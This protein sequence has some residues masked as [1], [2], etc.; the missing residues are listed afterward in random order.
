MKHFRFFPK[1]QYNGKDVIDIFRRAKIQSKVK[2]ILAEY[3]DVM[4]SDNNRPDSLAFDAYED[5]NLDWV[6][7]YANEI[8]D[9]IHD[10]PLNTNDF[11]AYV[12]QKYN[13]KNP[14]QIFV[15]RGKIRQVWVDQSEDQRIVRFNVNRI[16]PLRVQEIVKHPYREQYRRI[17]DIVDQNSFVIN[18]PFALPF[19]SSPSQL[20]SMQVYSDTHSYWDKKTGL[21]IDY[22]MWSQLPDVERIRKTYYEYEFETNEE[23][24]R[25]QYIGKKQAR[26][27]YNEL[28]TI[29]KE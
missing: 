17:I 25:I 21:Q 26:E 11:N 19:P 7:F 3:D 6:L 28:I 14:D 24:R 20:E 12:Q 1:I 10:W 2:N 8:H 18:E 22:D 5:P 15:E 4:I 29:F 16:T 27:L 9:P 13:A 23:K